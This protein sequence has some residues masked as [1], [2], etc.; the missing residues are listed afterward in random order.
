MYLSSHK[1]KNDKHANIQGNPYSLIFALPLL[2]L[3]LGTIE[4]FSSSRYAAS[5]IG[6]GKYYI[7]SL[8]ILWILLGA[9]IGVITAITPR[10]IIKKTSSLL[11]WI[12]VLLLFFTFI[13]GHINGAARWVS[14]AGFTLQPSEFLKITLPIFLAF[15]YVPKLK[16]HKTYLEHIN[17]DIGLLIKL[18]SIPIIL[19]F[20]Q[21]DLST[22]SLIVLEIA[23][24]YVLSV[25]KFLLQDLMLL[26]VAFITLV[27]VGINFASFRRT[28]VEVYKNLLLQGKITD[29]YG[30]GNQIF[31]ILIAVGSGGLWGK[32]IG[33]SSQTGGALVE[34]T[35]V[36]DSISAVIFE[37]L[38][39]VGGSILVLSFAIWGIYTIYIL[40]K[41]RAKDPLY[42]LALIT[43]IAEI[44]IQAFVHFSVNISLL[45]LT[46]IALPFISYGG[47]FTFVS[48]ITMGLLFGFLK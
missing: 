6:H 44:T 4:V 18:T 23:I 48:L 33:H 27:F 19:I 8:H 46:G 37:E 14:I 12:N 13:N 26:S 40:Y 15:N 22:L 43:L 47:S 39:F 41:Y 2:W 42:A 45:P 30:T 17:H 36:T 9:I 20:L 24:I 29:P 10:Q 1:I 31:N 3:I 25:K 5:L 28:R 21:P 32:G 34:S 16:E 7:V 35:A 38:G 11:Y